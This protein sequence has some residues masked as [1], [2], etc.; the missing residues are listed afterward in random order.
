MVKGKVTTLLSESLVQVTFGAGL[1]SAVQ[2]RDTWSPLFSVW[3]PEM[4][5]IFGASKEVQKNTGK[6]INSI[7]RQLGK[8]KI[9]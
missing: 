6:E 3:L 5:V 2:F 9:L 4:C 8:V 1:P 7:N